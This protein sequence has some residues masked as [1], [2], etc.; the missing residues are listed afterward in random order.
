MPQ[1]A[2]VIDRAGL[3]TV[4][5]DHPIPEVGPDEILIRTKAV[6]LNPIDYKHVDGFGVPG[7]QFGCDY[8]GT[9]EQV[10]SMVENK[11][12]LGCKVAG[13]IHGGSTH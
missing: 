3:A 5:D 2:L 13:M 10:G 1:R 4:H 8:A 12:P 11:F 9:V 6:A 7:C